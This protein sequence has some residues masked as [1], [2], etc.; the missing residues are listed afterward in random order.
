V[1]HISRPAFPGAVALPQFVGAGEF[2]ERDF[3][4]QY[5]VSQGAVAKD[6]AVAVAGEREWHVQQFGVLD[7]LCHAGVER[8]GV[9]LGLDHRQRAI[10]TVAQHVVGAAD[11]GLVACGTMATHH[12]A[13]GLEREF[14]EHLLV[15]VPT[16]GD[17][18]RRDEFQADVRFGQCLLI[19]EA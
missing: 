5:A 7:R 10:R 15:H 4:L 17:Q 9:V 1:T 18:G 11:A 6:E 8:M 16:A 19:H 13:A 3:A 2:V 14:L 12:H